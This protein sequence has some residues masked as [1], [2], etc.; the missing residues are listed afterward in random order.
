MIA[1]H[2][3]NISTGIAL[4][5]AP[6]AKEPHASAR[7]AQAIWS[8]LSR[9][10]VIR[11]HALTALGIIAIAALLWIRSAWPE[12]GL[13]N[14]GLEWMGRACIIVA[15]LGRCACMLYLGGRKGED[16]VDKGPYSV[17]RNPL[18]V[19]SVS[20]VFGIGLQ[21]GS[22]IVG[23][24]L[25]TSALAI[26]RWIVGKE[27]ILLRAN[28]AEKF[29]RYCAQVPRFWPRPSLWRSPE[30]VTVDLQGVWNTVRDA[31][32]YFLAIPLFEG[33]EAAQQAGLI[34]ARLWLF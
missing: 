12:S 32:P 1:S 33:I 14:E 22:L 23:L 34:H 17:S 25:A 24:V 13:V 31:T 15:I 11:R 2:R 21:T 28:F 27:E 29:D 3:V 26:F 4:R 8:R 16:L 19:F 10:Q 30:Y 6:Q 18:Y 5:F 7:D 20:A 9:A